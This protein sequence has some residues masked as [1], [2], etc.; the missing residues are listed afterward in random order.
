MKTMKSI[1]YIAAFM[2]CF[3][4]FAQEKTEKTKKAENKT[5][6]KKE[7]PKDVQKETEVKTIKVKKG[8]GKVEE[9]K[10]KVTTTK[11]QTIKSEPIPDHY[12]NSKRVETPIK[13]TQTVFV[14]LD[15]DPFYDTKSKV[16]YYTNK[17]KE[18]VFTRDDDG[19]V[20]SFDNE[21]EDV[22]FGKARLTSSN[23]YYLLKTN[24]YSGIGYFNADGDF[25]VE[26]YDET[27]DAM[28]VQTFKSSSM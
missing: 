23:R 4:A 27:L 16:V 22:I 26:Y 3:T 25:V 1:M 2:F 12:E 11:E 7:D 28:V 9:K 5:E 19:F 15:N 17:D 20:V 24:D 21:N 10:I 6:V 13:V 14:D 18:Y 8:E